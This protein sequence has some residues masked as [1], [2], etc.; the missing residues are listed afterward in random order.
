MP[1]KR[2]YGQRA[3]YR[4]D[5]TDD[6]LMD[7]F[8]HAQDRREDVAAQKIQAIQRGRQDRE[9]LQAQDASAAKIQAIQRG[10]Q[11]RKQAQLERRKRQERE[12]AAE[13]IQA[14]QRGRQAR[15][16]PL[17]SQYDWVG[18]AKGQSFY[19]GVDLNNAPVAASPREVRSRGDSTGLVTP[20]ILSGYGSECTITGRVT[21]QTRQSTISLP[22]HFTTPFA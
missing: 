21:S 13:K 15:K 16:K 14:I 12:A 5:V 3:G 18:G 19:G 11:T 10:R 6:E 1:S 9:R 17:R 7:L 22:S 20:G 2:R 4:G 8:E